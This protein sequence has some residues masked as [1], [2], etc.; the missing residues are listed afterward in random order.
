MT[1]GVFTSLK[2][3]VELIISSPDTLP[4]LAVYK[5]YIISIVIF[6]SLTYLKTIDGTS[7]NCIQYKQYFL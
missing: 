2:I 4:V 1:D 6:I 5:L 7:I 3:E